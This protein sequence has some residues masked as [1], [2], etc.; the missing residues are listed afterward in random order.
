M[1]SG[2]PKNFRTLLSDPKADR[3][4]FRT[5]LSDP[6]VDWRKFRKYQFG[7]E[8][9]N[10]F[11]S[12]VYNTMLGTPKFHPQSNI[13]KNP[14]SKI[15]KLRDPQ[16]ICNLLSAV[17]V[18]IRNFYFQSTF[19][20]QMR[21]IHAGNSNKDDEERRKSLTEEEKEEKTKSIWSH[22]ERLDFR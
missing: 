8:H 15:P 6:K 18:Y 4:K 11:M 12:S 19:I 16:L 14:I 7:L 2:F 22:M 3:R 9:L 1:L 5:L 20:K 10:P 21:I 17:D 13:P